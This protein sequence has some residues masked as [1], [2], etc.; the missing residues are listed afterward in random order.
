MLK[1]GQTGGASFTVPGAP[2][3]QQLAGEFHVVR[4]LQG[5][6]SVSETF[7]TLA[8]RTIQ[9]APA[10]PAPTITDVS[11]AYRRIRAE[12][13]LPSS[14][15]GGALVNISDGARSISVS[16]T[17][18]WLGGLAVSLEIP[19]FGGTAGWN[20]AWGPPTS[21]STGWGVSATG[22]TGAQCTEGAR[23]V[24]TVVSGQV[25]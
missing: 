6:S 4:V 25:N 9:P 10:L 14:Y 16:A 17:A 12:L 3:G 23:T 11:G 20:N 18:A 13:T 1:S 22:A 7:A 19:D 2:S 5:F 21:S 15:N 24:S 8:N